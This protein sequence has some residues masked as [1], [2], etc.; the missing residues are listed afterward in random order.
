MAWMADVRIVLL[1]YAVGVLA[2]LAATDARP[3]RRVALALL[4]PIGP[5]AFVVTLAVLLAA[6]L[7][8][9]PIV[10]LG[11]AAAAIGWW[12]VSR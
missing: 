12:A 7:I 9:Y 4:W 6:S 10:G 2:G 8:A 11:I 1:I 5:A 3:A